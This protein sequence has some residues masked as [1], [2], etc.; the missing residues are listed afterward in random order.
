M[1]LS[2][3]CRIQSICCKHVH[4]TYTQRTDSQ[5][6][7]L[8]LTYKDI[9]VRPLHDIQLIFLR[10]S[11]STFIWPGT[12]CKRRENLCLC[13]NTRRPLTI[14]R[15]WERVWYRL[16]KQA[17][18]G[19]WRVNL[20]CLCRGVFRSAHRTASFDIVLAIEVLFITYSWAIRGAAGTFV[21]ILIKRPF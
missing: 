15:N 19:Q 14:H 20:C 7:P 11:N 8:P 1:L 5:S 3:L 2:L 4:F 10:R 16:I 13:F 21:D 6:C 12:L 18:Y 17:Y 9:P